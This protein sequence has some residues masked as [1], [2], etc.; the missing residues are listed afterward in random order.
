[1]NVTEA[2]HILLLYRPRSVDANGPQ[3]AAALSL[4]KQDVEL[5]RWLAE[6]CARQETLRAKFRQIEPPAGLKEQIISEHAASQRMVFWRRPLALAAA[7]VLVCVSLF[8]L[9]SQSS[10]GNDLATYRGRMV[11][12]ALTGYAMDLQTNNMAN[13]R[14]YLAQ[15]QAPADFALPPGLQ[16]VTV[17]GCAV[18][19][20]Q[21]AN[22]TLICF[23]TG[24]PLPPGE[25]S[26]LWLFVIDRDSLK[27]APK[28]RT[29]E[30]AKVNRLIT[31]TWVEGAK[32]YL[33]GVAGNEQTIRDYL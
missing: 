2:K 12:A 15:R 11:R 4:A 26:D 16:N 22:V 23:R 13:L 9:R 14:A 27:H 30:L 3:V 8:L 25:S 18:E 33:L 21:R 17:T 6:H 1:V 7:V 10:S 20:W 31:A 19:K 28:S 32:V 5:A 24:K 29:P